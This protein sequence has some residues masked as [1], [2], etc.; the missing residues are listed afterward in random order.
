[1]NL[2]SLDIDIGTVA[3]GAAEDLFRDG[4][5]QII[6]NIGD[7]SRPWKDKRKLT[8]TFEVSPNEKRDSVILTVK[9]SLKLADP[10][11][12]ETLVYVAVDADGTVAGSEAARPVQMTV[13]PDD[14]PENVKRFER[15]ES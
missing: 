4:M 14:Q 15:K 6:R 2:N 3:D 1:M 10:K 5:G 13:E 9:Q 11:P 7:H 8:I 12:A